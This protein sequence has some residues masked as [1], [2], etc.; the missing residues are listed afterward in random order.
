MININKL[1]NIIFNKFSLALLVIALSTNAVSEVFQ[2]GDVAPRG[3]PDGQ[4]NAADSLILQ[5]MVL[6]E[7]IPTDDEKLIGDVAPLNSPDGKLDAG[8]LVVQQRAILGLV[9]LNTIDLSTLPVPIL[10]AI[11]LPSTSSNPYPISGST[12][13]NVSINIYVN[14]NVQRQTVSDVNGDFSI[15]VYLYDGS[16]NIHATVYNATEEG[17]ASNTVSVEYINTINRI[18]GDASSDGPISVD[19]VWTPGNPAQAYTISSDLTVASGVQFVIQPG[20]TVFFDD[21]TTLKVFGE[22]RVSNEG[23][24]ITLTSSNPNPTPGSWDGIVI[25]GNAKHVID[26]ALIEWAGIGVRLNTAASNLTIRNTSFLNISGWGVSIENYSGS[27]TND[28]NVLIDNVLIDNTANGVKV[29]SGRTNVSITNSTIQNISQTGVLFDRADGVISNNTINLTRTAITLR[30]SSPLIT[31][32]IL[33]N[34]NYGILLYAT[35]DVVSPQIKSNTII[36]NTTGIS[37]NATFSDSNPIIDSRNIITNN[38]VGVIIERNVGQG[39]ARPKINNNE[40]HSNSVNIEAGL[41]TTTI[42]AKNNW[43]GTTVVSDIAASINDY[44]DYERLRVIDYSGFLDAAGGNPATGNYLPPLITQN[45]ILMAGATYQAIGDVSVAS[46]VTLT[47]EAGAVLQFGTSMDLIID[48]TLLVNGTPTNPVI[49]TSSNPFPLAGDWSGIKLEALSINNV[50]DGAVVEYA[51]TGIEVKATSNDSLITNSAIRNNS[52]S[53]IYFNLASGTAS[54]NVING[55]TIDSRASGIWVQKASPLIDNNAIYNN[56]YGIYISRGSSNV[57]EDTAPQIINNNI[58]NNTDGI[59]ALSVAAQISGNI[60][61]NNSGSGIYIS[62]GAPIVNLG[63]VIT[64]NKY[65][66]YLG[67]DTVAVVDGNIII[68][69]NYGILINANNST[70]LQPTIT[71]NDIYNNN[72]ANLYLRKVPGT[73]ALNISNNWWGTDIIVDIRTT[74]T[75]FASSLDALVLLSSIAPVSNI[76][77]A[78]P[79]RTLIS[80]AYISPEISPGVK[81]ATTYTATLTRPSNWNVSIYNQAQQLVKTYTGTGLNVNV[82]WN[83]SDELLSPVVDG[84]YRFVLT[85]DGITTA[86]YMTVDNTLPVAAITAPLV[87]Q[88]ITSTAVL[89]IQG[90]VFDATYNDFKIEMAN[91]LTPAV[92]DYQTLYTQSNVVGERILPQ[93]RV[94]FTWLYND[95]NGLQQYGDRTVKLTVT[96][97]AGNISVHAVSFTLDYLTFSNV[98]I[99]NNKIN[100]YLDEN[101]S[102]VFT[103]NK[104]A[105]HGTVKIQMVMPCDKTFIV[106]NW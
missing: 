69:N 37:I 9:N 11:V 102:V 73:T 2:L 75:G 14:E 28:T 49:F 26:N 68:D 3:A 62:G 56:L 18:Q 83:G 61:T 21:G 76:I 92:G 71:T 63:N 48:G 84:L 89:N 51:I 1:Y 24:Q 30:S 91:S 29:G 40:I 19:T 7:I 10:D 88:T 93:A 60:V 99:T 39:V 96:D 74:I 33:K 80:E 95:I 12:S 36:S 27:L 103:L 32:N 44:T 53:G 98:S 8:D 4:L 101:I 16:N 46:G 100:P 45:T 34:S 55:H 13:P 50:I 35:N 42:D 105:S 90:S 85:V 78:V 86:Q 47:I 87:D 25:Y 17:L 54:N 94:L 59:Y 106:M 77:S 70:L 65:G 31:G 38:G 5:R 81:D 52:I 23:G 22:L 97:K 79:Y 43:W 82:T 72:I 58:S 15:N 41:D 67:G 66:I 104:P 20:T 64:N 57:A 6:G